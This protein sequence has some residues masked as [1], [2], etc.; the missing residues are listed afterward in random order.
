MRVMTIVLA[1]MLAI[2]AADSA[3]AAKKKHSKWSG[4]EQ[5]SEQSTSN[6]FQSEGCGLVGCYRSGSQKSQKNQKGQN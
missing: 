1:G 3:F 5:S 2:C 4:S 6:S